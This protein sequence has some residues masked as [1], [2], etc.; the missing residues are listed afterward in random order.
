MRAINFL[1]A[2]GALALSHS[3]SLSAASPVRFERNDGQCDPRVRFLKRG[4]DATLF[5]T[6]R[7]LVLSARTAENSSSV[8]R[9]TLAGARAPRAVEGLDPLPGDM[10]IFFGSGAARVRARVESFARVRAAGVYPGI[11]LEYRGTAGE[12]EYDFI[13]SPGADPRRITLAFDGAGPLR[14]EADGSLVVHGAAGELRHHAPMLYQEVGGERRT[15]AGGFVVTGAHTA[16]FRVGAHDRSLPL[17]IDP[18]LTSSTYLGGNALDAATAI[19][20]DGSGNVYVT[21]QTASANFPVRN[22]R[23]GPYAGATDVFVA[24]LDAALSNLLWAD[25]LGGSGLDVASGIA[26]D[27]S[28]RVTIAGETNSAD[29]PVTAGAYQSV[30]RL[31]SDAFVLRLNASGSAIDAAT[32]LGGDGSLDR[33]DALALDGAGNA[34]ITGR[35]NSTNFPS[36]AGAFQTYYRGGDF[37]SYVAKLDLTQSGSA[38]LV[39]ASYLGGSENDAGFGIAVDATGRAS[40]TGGTRSPDFPSTLNAVQSGA[41]STDAFVITLNAAGSQLAYGTLLGGSGVDRGNAIAVDAAT[42][43]VTGMTASSDFPVQAAAQPGSAGG[44]NDAF[45]VRLDPSAS[46]TAS[47]V[48]STYLGGGGDDRGNALALD[49]GVIAVTGQTTSP[50]FP[51]L[52]PNQAGNAGKN[53]VFLARY[54]ASGTTLDSTPLGGS[55]EDRATSISV[56]AGIIYLAGASDSIDFPVLRAFQ[57]TAGGAGDA[58]VM[59]LDPG[60]APPPPPLG[61]IPIKIP[62]VP[63][64]GLLLLAA[65]L[66]GCG[67]IV[68]RSLCV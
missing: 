14:L 35:I 62:G 38:S 10:R 46:G 25:Y 11:D 57:S 9:M 33:A 2:A 66:A 63:P 13:L 1:L 3:S 23:P 30:K 40:V 8:L 51:K 4:R 47:L 65:A 29:F 18:V 28:G 5:I 34:Y 39:Y 19:A 6:D 59:R 26:V 53:D 60:A 68:L 17:V 41:S 21:G 61:G 49:G 45:V 56:A 37:D 20:T 31:G 43:F 27:A 36:T 15:V 67:S 55:G 12:L 42:I 16:G 22:A 32:F 64:V 48:F 54:A 52:L 58:F 50:D 24:K 7:G 44:A